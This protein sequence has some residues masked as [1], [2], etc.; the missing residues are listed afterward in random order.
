MNEKGIKLY[1]ENT[2]KHYAVPF[3]KAIQGRV[4]DFMERF[5]DLTSP[6]DTHPRYDSFPLNSAMERAL[7]CNAILV[8]RDVGSKVTFYVQVD[9]STLCPIEYTIV[10]SK[11]KGIKRVWRNVLPLKE[12]PFAGTNEQGL[13]LTY[14]AFGRKARV[15]EATDQQIIER[16]DTYIPNWSQMTDAERM[17]WL[18]DW[19]IGHQ[20]S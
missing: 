4:R 14:G 17:R 13:F 3:E 18:D 9:A 16:M 15:C 8:L 2:S 11:K 5:R 6:S 7:M 10:C 20:Q 1:E 19:I 12:L